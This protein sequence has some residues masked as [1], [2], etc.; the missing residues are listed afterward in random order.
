[1]SD[2]ELGY[3]DGVYQYIHKMCF[4]TPLIFLPVYIIIIKLAQ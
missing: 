1:M 4:Y 3:P 2:D